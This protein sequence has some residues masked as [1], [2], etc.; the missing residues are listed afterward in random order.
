MNQV[1]PKTGR[2]IWGEINLERAQ[3]ALLYQ[4]R[5]ILS[6]VEQFKK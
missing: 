1:L 6:F 4:N 2:N 3:R 5:E